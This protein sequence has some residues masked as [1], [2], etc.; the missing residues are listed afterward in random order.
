MKTEYLLSPKSFKFNMLGAFGLI[1]F[2]ETMI[3]Q[4]WFSVMTQYRW[5]SVTVYVAGLGMLLLAVEKI[6]DSYV[7]KIIITPQEITFQSLGMV[8]TV[9]WNDAQRIDTYQYTNWP[10]DC[11]CAPRNK[12][13]IKGWQS[14]CGYGK[15]VRIPLEDFSR[16]WRD[17]ELGQQIK[18]YAPHLFQ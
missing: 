2:R 3:L 6:I 11:I 7:Q 17:T 1:L 9:K 13:V 18:Q 10:Q 8:V 4:Q 12:A 16:N 15:E 5:L 14:F